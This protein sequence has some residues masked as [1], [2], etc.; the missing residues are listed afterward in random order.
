MRSLPDFWRLLKLR[1]ASQFG[2]GLFQAGLAGGLLFNPERAADPWAVAGAFAVLFLPYSVLGPFAGALL[3]RWDRR[4]VL[5]VANLA[6]RQ[7]K[8]GLSEGM[9]VA[10]GPGEKEVFLLG[11]DSGAKPGQ[12]AH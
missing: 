9:I 11:V 8:F 2:D 10:V 7:M 12:R 1:A 4:L 6:P 5:I 3:D